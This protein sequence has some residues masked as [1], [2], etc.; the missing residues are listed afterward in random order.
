[1]ANKNLHVTVMIDEFKIMS[2][3]VTDPECSLNGNYKEK[4]TKLMNLGPKYGI[5]F[6]LATQFFTAGIRV[7][8][9]EVKNGI[10][11]SVA[12]KN[13]TAEI[14]GTLGLKNPTDYEK[15][16]ME[17]LPV[18][19]ALTLQDRQGGT[20]RLLKSKVLHI[21]DFSELNGMIRTIKTSMEPRSRYDFTD[22]AAFIYKSR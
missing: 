17:T 16:C 22:A 11:Q 14:I 10:P 8:A 3:I 13:K 20:G 5:Y 21:C 1:M 4:F 19:H 15:Q 6:I 7:L 2:D 12:M 9:D 18:F